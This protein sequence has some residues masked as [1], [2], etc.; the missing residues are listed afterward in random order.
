[1]D[2]ERAHLKS[3][4]PAFSDKAV[5][6]AMAL[7]VDRKGIVDVILGRAGM[8]T[9]NFLN[10]Q[11]R[12]RSP[13]MTFEFN[14]DKANQVLDDAGWKKGADGVRA[15]AGIELEL[16][17][18]TPVV[19]FGSDVTNADTMHKL[20]ADLM[21]V[22]NV[23]T[24]P[25][26]QLVLAIHRTDRIPQKVN[27]WIGSNRVRWQNAEYDALHN[28]LQR[29]FDPVKRA[30]LAIQMNDLVVSDGHV[31]PLYVRSRVSGVGNKLEPVLS[32]WDNELW[33]LGC[34]TRGS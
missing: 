31:I 1:M 6:T 14:I 3:L 20:W 5:R 19:F 7:L 15:K 28:A 17:A 18:V 21:W 33:A 27:K 9:A 13:N 10:A 4:H 26:P 8:V 30:A 11:A 22:A 25:E 23:M 34:W 12:L 16:K 29:E 32:I 24:S 2:G